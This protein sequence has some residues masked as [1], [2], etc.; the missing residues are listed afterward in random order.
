MRILKAVSVVMLIWGSQSFASLTDQVH[1]IRARTAH[2]NKFHPSLG[3]S[4]TCALNQ[5]SMVAAALKDL[6]L[7][8]D[9]LHGTA[10]QPMDPLTTLACTRP[11]CGGGGGGGGCKTCVAPDESEIPGRDTL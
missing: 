4:V 11:E 9:L 6:K 8:E 1:E 2:L 5:K 10:P 3:V 7:L